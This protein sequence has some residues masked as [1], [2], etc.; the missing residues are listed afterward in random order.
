MKKAI[1]SFIAILI[2]PMMLITFSGC[3]GGGAK[4]SANTTTLGQELTDLKAAYDQGVISEK[5]YERLKKDVIK[6]HK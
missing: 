2:L 6:K 3:G 5:E 4:M 1:R